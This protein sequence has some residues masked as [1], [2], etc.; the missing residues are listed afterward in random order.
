[1]PANLK[2]NDD[3]FE[4]FA[5]NMNRGTIVDSAAK[6]RLDLIDLMQKLKIETDNIGAIDAK[7][8]SIKDDIAAI[9]MVQQSISG[10]LHSPSAETVSK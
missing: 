9:K 2:V 1:M 3:Y 4:A 7:S 6:S 8:L 5:V 10:Y